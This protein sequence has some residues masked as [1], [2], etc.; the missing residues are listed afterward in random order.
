MSPE[1]QSEWSDREVAEVARGNP[2]WYH[3][4]ELRPG[5]VTEGWF[6]LRPIVQSLPW[7]DVEG[8][9]CLDIG[10]YDGFLA[11]ELERRGAREVI[12]T[13]VASH[14]D[15]DFPPAVR[16]GGVDLLREIAGEKGRGFE[17]A[18]QALGSRVQKHLI[19]VYELSPQTVGTFDVIV[20]GSLLLH[21]RD[22]F[23]ALEAVRRVCGG[24]FL[25]CEQIDV[26][27]SLSHRRLPLTNLS[28]ISKVQ[29]HVPN[30]AGHRAMIKA[31][32]FNIE[33]TI[34]P[35][36][37]PFGPAHP[38]VDSTFRARL[39]SRRLTGRWGVPHSALLARPI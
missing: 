10:T 23:R 30:L 14:E 26:G 28:R 27:L 24:T 33:R 25:S 9:R 36:S 7:P 31:A 17:I 6:D 37:I 22:P 5:V 32:G 15:W 34:K 3:T 39:R 19:S 8:K 20:C 38:T 1:V 11:F 12:A 13:D 4:M 21:L 2:L 16:A 29:W 18:A 35:Y